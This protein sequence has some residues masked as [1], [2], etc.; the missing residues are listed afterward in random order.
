MLALLIK[1]KSICAARDWILWLHSGFVACCCCWKYLQ[2]EA[3]TIPS[4]APHR[5]N[6]CVCLSVFSLSS[7]SLSVCVLLVV[8]VVLVVVEEISNLRT[9]SPP[10]PPPHSQPPKCQ[11]NFVVRPH[12]SCP[13]SLAWYRW[14]EKFWK[15]IDLRRANQ[16]VSLT[17]NK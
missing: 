14:F 1:K 16:T 7:L 15:L 5:W 3:T 6:V 4:L 8:V 2:R 9:I 10:S 13:P 12:T 17:V 11:W